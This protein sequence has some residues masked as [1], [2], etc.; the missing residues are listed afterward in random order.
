MYYTISVKGE[1]DSGTLITGT[2]SIGGNGKTELNA[3]V[4][5]EGL[6]IR[7]AGAGPGGK[8]IEAGSE[9]GPTEVNVLEG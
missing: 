9:A 5:I 4:K 6:G 8:G 7:L 3:Q 1:K 2:G